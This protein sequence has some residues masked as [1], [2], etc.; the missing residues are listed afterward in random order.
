LEIVLDKSYL[1]A[2]GKAQIHRLCQEHTVLFLESLFYELLTTTVDQ[3]IKCFSKLPPTENPVALIPR[4]GPLLRYEIAQKKPARPLSAH[5]IGIPFSFNPGLLDP[6]FKI[7]DNQGNDIA[8]WRREVD[9]DVRAFHE[10]AVSITTWCP[11][12]LELRGRQFAEKCLELKREAANN[13]RVVKGIYNTLGIAG[14]PEA[15]EIDP[16]WVIFR[17]LQSH[18]LAYLDYLLRNGIGKQTI[19]WIRIEHDIHDIQYATY[20]AHAGALAS[21]DRKVIENFLLMAP[22]GFLLE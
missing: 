21:K 7:L 10:L 16:S 9:G 6:D 12:L 8:D 22:N 4:L 17:N 1:E 18:I 15:S 19:S 11:E 20:G 2:S 13:H 3:R 5:Q 14:F